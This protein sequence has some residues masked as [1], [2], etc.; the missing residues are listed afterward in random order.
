MAT[1]PDP[2]NDLSPADRAVF[3]HVASVRAHSDG[4]PHQSEVY[5]RMF[6]NPGV[7]ARVSAFGEQIRF[8]GVLPGEVRELAILQYASRMHAGYEWSHHQRPAHLEG[9]SDTSIAAVTRGEVPPDLPL[10]TQAVLRAVDA[11]VALRSIPEADQNKIVEA[12]G[13]AGAVELV[14][15]CGLYATMSYMCAAFDIEI[16]PGLPAP[17]F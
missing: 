2:T 14:A 3:D 15:I 16:E 5:L 11:A 12:Y 10:Q 17:P 9:I 6:N 4:R 1:L 13:T 7:A 8:H